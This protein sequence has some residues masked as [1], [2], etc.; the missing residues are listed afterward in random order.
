MPYSFKNKIFE[1][2]NKAN[3]YKNDDFIM[4]NTKDKTRLVTNEEERLNSGYKP[5][6]NYVYNKWNKYKD[7]IEIE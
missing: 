4:I 7:N 1:T 5:S 6:Y 2:L 3:E